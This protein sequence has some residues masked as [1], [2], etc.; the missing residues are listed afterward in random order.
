MPTLI[1]CL[2]FKDLPQ[3]F[4]SF[5]TNRF[6]RQQQRNEIMKHFLKLVK[7]NS[8]FLKNFVFRCFPLF[9]K[10]HKYFSHC[11]CLVRCICNGRRTIAESLRFGETAFSGFLHLFFSHPSPCI[12]KLRKN[13]HRSDFIPCRNMIGWH[14]FRH[15]FSSARPLG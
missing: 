4:L 15:K 11:C 7:Q 8:Y 5:A 6:V 2:I 9:S 14:E 1:D 3:A 12:H 10:H 13:D